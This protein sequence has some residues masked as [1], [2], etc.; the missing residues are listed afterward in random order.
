MQGR[1][2]RDGS[3][4]AEPEPQHGGTGPKAVSSSPQHAQ[5]PGQAQ[6]SDGKDGAG[7]PG[8]GAASAAA[9]QQPP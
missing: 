5:N 6:P 1:F 3:A 2:K 9:G 7:R 4:S 8:Q